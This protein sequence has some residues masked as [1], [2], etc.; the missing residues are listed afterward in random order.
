[1][2]DLLH[3]PHGQEVKCEVHD[4]EQWQN[5]FSHFWRAITDKQIN[6]HEG[7]TTSFIHNPALR[8]FRHLLACTI[9]GRAN[10][11]KVNSKE[12]FYMF[13]AI[14]K[15]KINTVPFLFSHMLS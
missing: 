15:I 1:M 14:R 8:Y 11:N 3:F 2:A 5:T 7:N 12:M 13:A 4:D 9:F 10:L 6:S